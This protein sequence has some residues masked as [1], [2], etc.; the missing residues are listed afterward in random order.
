M[1]L[2][3]RTGFGGRH[4]K[5]WC[6]HAVFGHR[7]IRNHDQRYRLRRG[8]FRGD[9]KL[10]LRPL[11]YRLRPGRSARRYFGRQDQRAGCGGG[12]E[13]NHR[14]RLYQHRTG[15]RVRIYTENGL[16]VARRMGNT[17]RLNLGEV[18]LCVDEHGML[19]INDD[20]QTK[21]PY[22]HAVGNFAGFPSLAST[23]MEQV[24][25]AAA[26]AFGEVVKS[27]SQYFPYDIYTIPKISVVGKNNT[28]L[29]EAGTAY[30]VV[31][32]PSGKSRAAK[33]W[34]TSPE[35]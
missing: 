21:I 32:R 16:Y 30:E 29:T 26:H 34:A 15:E 17:E 25:R 24:R 7:H 20:Y 35:S 5:V 28:E 12:N 18:G 2:A 10:R 27:F 22:I 9:A 23:G 6:D 4:M 3:R 31:R 19:E 13:I 1:G 11:R 33:L 14:R 8:V